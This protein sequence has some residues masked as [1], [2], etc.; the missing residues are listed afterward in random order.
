MSVKLWLLTKELKEH[1]M[2]NSKRDTDFKQLPTQEIKKLRLRACKIE[3]MPWSICLQTR[4]A[5]RG[6]NVDLQ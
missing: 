4:Q 1:E 2:S 3:L 6:A 5:D